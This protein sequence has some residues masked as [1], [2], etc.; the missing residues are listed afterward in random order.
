MRT[1]KP[2]LLCLGLVLDR[3][4]PA[5]A[6]VFEV[7]P[8]TVS[9]RRG[10]TSQ[11]LTL[12]NRATEP[13]RLQLKVYRWSEDSAGNMGVAPSEEIVVF[14]TLLEI[15]GGGAR[16]IRLGM[17]TPAG[18]VEK[19]FRLVVEEMPAA[20]APTPEAQN[21]VNVVARTSIPVFVEPDKPKSELK[22]ATFQ[23]RGGAIH[24]ELKNT[25]N[26]RLRVQ[27][28]HYTGEGAKLL[29]AFHHE[30]GGWY[31]LGGGNRIYNVPLPSGMCA[32][33]DKLSVLIH[34]T[35]APVRATVA[36]K[37]SDFGN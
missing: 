33:L 16:K 15:E 12:R 5:N 19:T 11:L 6:G 34:S 14:P 7:N 20:T 31:L 3:S 26:S 8:V 37:P 13:I 28:I 9:L 17:L 36:V 24:L 4:A 27:R 18:G 10:M 32:S 1:H 2:S 21:T 25:G 23:V 30:M 22:L 35:E 29:A